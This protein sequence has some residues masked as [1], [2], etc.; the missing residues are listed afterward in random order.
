[1][2]I[3]AGLLD[4]CVLPKIV[5]GHFSKAGSTQVGK[6]YAIS[7]NPPSLLMGL[8]RSLFAHNGLENPHELAL[9]HLRKVE[10]SFLHRLLE[11]TFDKITML[12]YSPG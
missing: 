4:R 5:R 8:V 6:P 12:T 7:S 9:W 1:M 11:K 10:V 2:V 3:K